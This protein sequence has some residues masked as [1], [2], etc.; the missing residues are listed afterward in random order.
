MIHLS[1]RR[2]IFALLFCLAGTALFALPTSAQAYR[3][4]MPSIPHA[5]QGHVTIIVLDM[6]GSMTTNDPQGLRCSAANAY[7]DLSGVNDY[8]G[9]VGLDN[10][11]GNRIGNNQFQ[12]AQIWT[13][14]INTATQRDQQNLRSIITN[15]SHSC[16]PDNTTPTYDALT[17]ALNMLG[18]VAA[19]KHLTG[20]VI[21]LTDGVPDPDTVPQIDKIKSDLVPQFKQH[22]WP[23]DTIA[24]GADGP[25]ASGSS[26]TFHDF[27][28]DVASGTGG[29]FYDDGKGQ[30][31]GISPLNIAPFF[32]DIFARRVGRTVTQ[33]IPPTNLDGGTT[34]RNFSV[35]DFTN[36]LDV[37]VVKDQPATTVSLVTPGGQTI[38]PGNGA[39]LTS[40]DP[41]Y[42]I[43][44]IHQPIAGQWEVHV[45]GNGQFLLNSL[46]SSNIGVSIDKVE[47][48]D[49]NLPSG[50]VWPLGQA[51][52]ISADLTSNGR[53]ITDNTFRVTG[54]IAST[55]SSGQYSQDFTLDDN[56][57]PGTYVGF[58][59]TPTSAP[60]GS[61]DI[62]LGVSTVSTANVLASSTKSIRLELFPVPLLI[63]P[64]TNAPTD[65]TINTTVLQWPLPIQFLYS[66]PVLSSLSGWPLQGHSALPY[67][68]VPGVVQWQ[69][70]TYPGAQISAQVFQENSTKTISATVIQDQ[71]GHFQLQFIPPT[72]GNYKLVFLTSGSYKDSHGDFGPT[73]RQVNV[74]VVPATPLQDLQ[75]GGVSIIYVLF[76]IFICFFISFL[77]TPGPYGEWER[78]Q[79]GN[80]VGGFRFSRSRRGLWQ[81]FRSRNIVYS[82][83]AGM[84]RGLIFR[85]ERGGI[86]ARVDGPGSSDWQAGDGSKLRPQFQRVREL[87]FRPENGDDADED[88]SRYT[89]IAQ[90]DKRPSLDDGDDTYHSRPAAGKAARSGRTHYG[91]DS[92][93]Y[94]AK[95][96]SN[97]SAKKNKN[98]Q[99]DDD[100]F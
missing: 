35:T 19:N 67:T 20:S 55:G 25:I 66:L 16:Q 11:N 84:P 82:R 9:I 1:L 3:N 89:L 77:L 92:D 75:A 53:V 59:T 14:P 34:K 36:D 91:S 23:V 37:V 47:L 63:S 81:S 46:K 6:S 17:K 78:I 30:I 83:Q 10:N 87:T 97:K 70:H 5:T 65:S 22:G 12:E 33:D 85:F 27:L 7:I 41:H 72:S 38:S 8:I 74:N 61:Y 90:H 73:V 68:N 58:V 31:A 40:Q 26:T 42:F 54:N 15:K 71:A 98:T 24:L 100:Y 56:A 94:S 29:K 39:V 44:S 88:V 13:D 43:F 86:E 57:A 48:K 2:S 95:K 52:R 51:L 18:N 60:A 96:R 28:G 69:G 93:S 4:S 21:L 32:V 79:G 45:T 62:K 49:A 50:D 64:K 99:W 76:L 80:V